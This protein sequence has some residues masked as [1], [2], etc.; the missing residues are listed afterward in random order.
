MNDSILIIFILT[1]ALA[2]LCVGLAEV[3]YNRCKRKRMVKDNQELMNA[4]SELALAHEP[5]G[6]RRGASQTCTC[7]EHV[8]ARWLIRKFHERGG[9]SL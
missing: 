8:H 1:A 2:W 5:R 3:S 4:L 9:K 6:V 7:K